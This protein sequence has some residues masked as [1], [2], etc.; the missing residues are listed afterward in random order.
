MLKNKPPLLF[1]PGFRGTHE[2]LVD[3]AV[4]MGDKGYECYYPDV[5]P[6]GREVKSLGEYNEK[7]YTKF[8]ADYIR[9]N[10]LKNPVLIGHSL[11]SIIAAATAKKYP[12]LVNK[13]LVLLSPISEKMP[14]PIAALQPLLMIFPNKLIGFITTKFML[15]QKKDHNKVRD[16]LEVTYRCGVHYTSRKDVRASAK[17]SANHKIG[18]FKPKK[19]ILI[20][21]GVKDRIVSRKK[22]EKLGEELKARTKFIENAGHLINYEEPRKIAEAIADFLEN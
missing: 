20:I 15:I 11:G 17:F 4:W 13:K 16:I 19:D 1:I 3:V 10:K 18:D 2:G 9:K 8:I 14:K 6:F 7:T 5:P 12:R 21:A 22:T